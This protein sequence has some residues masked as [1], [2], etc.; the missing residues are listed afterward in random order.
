M[1]YYY[2]NNYIFE[3][4]LDIYRLIEN[5]IIKQKNKII[6]DGA[7]KYILLCI[8]QAF[9]NIEL[10]NYDNKLL[11]RLINSLNTNIVN[12]NNINTI[13][14]NMLDINKLFKKYQIHKIKI[15]CPYNN[16]WPC[17]IISYQSKKNLFFKWIYY[18]I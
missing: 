4:I 11:N 13:F 15:N 17:N 16:K 9:L 7:Q 3:C 18:N 1:I 14:C 6:R 8:K 5:T 10:T 2:K 12:Y